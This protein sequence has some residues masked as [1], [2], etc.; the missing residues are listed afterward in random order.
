M[1]S[2]KEIFAEIANK[3]VEALAQ[4]I[5]PWQKPWTWRKPKLE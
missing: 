5:V 4:N 1:K 3:F 2:Q